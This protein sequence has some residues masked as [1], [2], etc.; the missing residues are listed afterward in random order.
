MEAI[1][2]IWNYVI[3]E[4]IASIL[5]TNFYSIVSL[6]LYMSILFLLSCLLDNARGRVETSFLRLIFTLN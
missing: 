1:V 6:S 5:L 4:A 2:T 3:L